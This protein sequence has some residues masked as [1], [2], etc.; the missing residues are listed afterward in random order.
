[1]KKWLIVLCVLAPAWVLTLLLPGAA[2]T[3]AQ[4]VALAGTSFLLEADGFQGEATNAKFSKAIDVL[5]WSWGAS[6]ADGRSPR[7]QDIS[8]TKY[9]DRTSPSLMEYVGTAQTIPWAKLHVI[10]SGETEQEYLRLCFT[11]LHVKSVSSGGS[12]G[13]DRLTE[14]VTFSYE[15]I[16]QRYAQQ[17]PDGS[18]DQAIEGSWDTTK[19]QKGTPAAC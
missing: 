6:N 10:K 12:F 8:F 4:A 7:F 11:G 1:L 19:N 2:S 5:A 13:E 17:K 14:N 18:L 3:P 15:T 16:V 9:I